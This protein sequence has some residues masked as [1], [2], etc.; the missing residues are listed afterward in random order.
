MHSRGRRTGFVAALERGV[1]ARW[2]ERTLAGP[3]GPGW[4]G[5]DGSWWE[6]QLRMWAGWPPGLARAAW[7]ESVARI[8]PRA[9]PPRAGDDMAGPAWGGAGWSHGLERVAGVASS[10]PAPT[11][12]LTCPPHDAS[13]PPAPAP[14]PTLQRRASSAA[15]PPA[16]PAP[17]PTPILGLPA[18]SPANPPRP[19]RPGAPAE[20]AGRL[21]HLKP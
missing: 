17:R 12:A 11:L 4:G 7:F 19:P 6:P 15:A 9:A 21:Q 5:L 14:R 13:I 8:T 1:G 3:V 2:V 18:S 10:Y 16:P 20:P